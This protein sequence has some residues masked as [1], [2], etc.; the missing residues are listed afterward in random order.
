MIYISFIFYDIFINITNI[1]S[2]HF[3]C[4]SHSL[5]TIQPPLP[6]TP[7]P[8]PHPPNPKQIQHLLMELVMELVHVHHSVA[9]NQNMVNPNEELTEKLNLD[10]TH[11]NLNQTKTGVSLA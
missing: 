6:T 7:P 9:A 8:P 1:I 5:G 3:K 10:V 11:P 4:Q 2:F